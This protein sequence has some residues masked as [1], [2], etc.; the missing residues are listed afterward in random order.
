MRNLVVKTNKIVSAVQSLSLVEARIIQL[1]IIDARESGCGLSADK[2]LRLSAS[3][4]AEMF[5][6]NPSNSY[7]TIKQAEE[8][9]FARRFSYVDDDGKVVKS[10]WVQQVKY[11]DNEGAIEIIFT[12]A[13]VKG[14]SRIDGAIDFFTE[15]LISDTV[16]FKSVYSIRLYEMMRQWRNADPKKMPMFELEMLRQQLGVESEQYKTMSN[17]K[18]RVLDN[19]IAEI[20]E[21]SDLNVSYDSIKSGKKIIGFKFKIKQKLKKA[22]KNNKQTTQ[23][24]DGYTYDMIAHLSMTDKQRMFFAK[25]LSKLYELEKYAVG[26]L[27][28]YDRLAEWIAED[29]LKPERADFYRPLLDKVGFKE[30]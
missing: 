2:P 25:K 29:L 7:N 4:Y 1:A 28:D 24:R 10:R 22:S 14:I 9:L 17:F 19:A 12:I 27:N 13:V 16:N 11:L 30:R 18:K 6:V 21:Y 20:N 26:D 5:K 23:G 8:T 3:R 15:Y